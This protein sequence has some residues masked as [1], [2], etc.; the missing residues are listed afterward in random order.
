MPRK[1]K[2]IYT[3]DDLIASLQKERENS[4]LKGDTVVYI[5][6]G[7]DIEYKAL[8]YVAIEKDDDGAICLVG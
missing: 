5:H 2:E 3:I 6:M 1:R 7:D 4:P 8:D